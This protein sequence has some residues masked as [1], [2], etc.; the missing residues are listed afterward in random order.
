MSHLFYLKFKID[1]IILDLCQHFLHFGRCKYGVLH[2]L[3]VGIDRY[4]HILYESIDRYLGVS[5]H[6]LCIVLSEL[7]R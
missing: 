7:L 6:Q 4:E 2:I 5:H 3:Q 1:L